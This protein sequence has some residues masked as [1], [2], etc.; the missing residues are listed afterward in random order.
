MCKHPKFISQILSFK[1]ESGEGNESENLP[2]A[3]SNW[4]LKIWR[5]L[6]CNSLYKTQILGIVASSFLSMTSSKLGSNTFRSGKHLENGSSEM[7]NSLCVRLRVI[8]S[9]D[10]KF[11]SPKSPKMTSLKFLLFFLLWIISHLFLHLSS[12][13]WSL[14]LLGAQWGPWDAVIKGGFQAEP[15][16]SL[17]LI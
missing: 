3:K 6:Q 1:I 15:V 16:G 14:Q 8:N 13:N 4:T 12:V 5:P 7:L 17:L 10:L 2:R 11:R 9:A